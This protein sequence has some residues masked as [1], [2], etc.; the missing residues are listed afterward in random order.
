MG[1]TANRD[2]P[3]AKTFVD[4]V[5]EAR[6]EAGNNELTAGEWRMED[7][8][9]ARLLLTNLLMY[10]SGAFSAEEMYTLRNNMM[11]VATDSKKITYINWYS[12]PVDDFFSG[13][14]HFSSMEELATVEGDIIGISSDYYD[15][16]TMNV[17]IVIYKKV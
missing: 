7:N 5:N 13:N 15:L 9:P 8:A 10:Q 14:Y 2:W 4:R 11:D 3:A 6:V 16:Q 17:C 1:T 12:M